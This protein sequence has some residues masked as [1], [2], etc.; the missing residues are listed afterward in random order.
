MA[1]RRED[2][3]YLGTGQI[4]YDEEGRA[5]VD[6]R[7]LRFDDDSGVR[8]GGAIFGDDD[9]FGGDDFGD[10]DGGKTMVKTPLTAIS[11]PSR[12]IAAGATETFTTDIVA[13]PQFAFDAE[14]AVLTATVALGGAAGTSLV[15]DAIGITKV[16]FGDNVVWQNTS[17][18]PLSV[19][20]SN[21]FLRA[22]VRGAQIRAGLDITITLS[23]TVRNTDATDAHST[24]YSATAAIFGMKEMARRC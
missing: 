19:L 14:D 7:T 18:V 15:L 4:R 3:T 17:P 23:H 2:L 13:R 1:L 22:L 11:T 10:D 8:T 20:A 12:S 24:T 16:L 9:D 21:S 5:Y 6:Q